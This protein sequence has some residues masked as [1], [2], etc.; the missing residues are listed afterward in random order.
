MRKIS[1]ALYDALSEG[2]T[3]EQRPWRDA[4][5]LAWAK[6]IAMIGPKAF[7]DFRDEWIAAEQKARDIATGRFE[8]RR[9]KIQLAAREV[10]E[11]MKDLREQA[12]NASRRLRSAA[13]G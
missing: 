9:M 6:I 10:A 13:Y 8:Q 1:S 5:L 4:A 2:Y 11:R 3:A 7:E 12:D